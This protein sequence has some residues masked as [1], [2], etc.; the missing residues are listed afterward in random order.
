MKTLRPGAR[1]VGPYVVLRFFLAVVRRAPEAPRDLSRETCSRSF[2]ASGLTTGGRGTGACGWLPRLLLPASPVG[3][4][5]DRAAS[6]R[7]PPAPSAPRFLYCFAIGLSSSFSLDGRK[8]MICHRG[9]RARLY[10]ESAK[11]RDG[12]CALRSRSGDLDENLAADQ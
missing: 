3:R 11:R 6:G 2:F 5:S 4:C 10:R 1:G 9:D 12:G 8:Q 7:F